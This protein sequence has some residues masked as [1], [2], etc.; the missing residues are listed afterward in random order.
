MSNTP[1]FMCHVYIKMGWL[2]HQAY[3]EPLLFIPPLGEN[4]TH[5]NRSENNWPKIF[6]PHK[7]IWEITPESYPS[8]YTPSAYETPIL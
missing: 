6:H 4:L 8:L 7:S 3:R 1:Y 2:I 5:A